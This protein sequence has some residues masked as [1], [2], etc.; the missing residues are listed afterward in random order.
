M[1]PIT[2]SLI[3]PTDAQLRDELNYVANWR[4]LRRQ[5]DAYPIKPMPRRV[6]AEYMSVMIAYLPH[7]RLYL[8]CGKRY[9]LPEFDAVFPDWPDYRS[10]SEYRAAKPLE[11]YYLRK[12]RHTERLR[13]FWLFITLYPHLH[14]HID[15]S[16]ARQYL[17]D[18]DDEALPEINL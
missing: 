1:T 9:V 15:L 3:M 14:T 17:Q 13:F 16:V 11:Q 18:G 5:T 10:V 4:E 7:E 8:S 2:Q 6:L 12:T